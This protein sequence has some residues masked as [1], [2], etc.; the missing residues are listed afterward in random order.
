MKTNRPGWPA[1]AAQLARRGSA[2][3][4]TGAG[5]FWEAFEARRHLYPQHPTPAHAHAR[6]APWFWAF[7]S[8]GATSLL[9]AC[10]WFLFLQPAPV[11]AHSAIHS[12][13]IDPEHGTV[14]ILQ[15]E[16]SHAAILWVANLDL[17][18]AATEPESQE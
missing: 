2:V 8:L 7:G 10:T 17:T 15:D 5:N 6:R 12:Y 1:I 14:M 16:T 18:E 9:A 13:E 3:P 11:Q 4:R